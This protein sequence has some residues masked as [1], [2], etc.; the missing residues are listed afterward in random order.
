ML[1]EKA[2]IT[3]NCDPFVRILDATKAGLYFTSGNHEEFA[4]QVKHL[5]NNPEVR[6]EMEKN[7]KQAVINT[8]NWEEASKQLVDLYRNIG[9]N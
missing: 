8:Y 5:Y 9:A 1:M 7:G 6:N 4:S 3:S 2:V